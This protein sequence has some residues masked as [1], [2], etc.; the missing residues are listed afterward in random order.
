MQSGSK[1]T[2]YLMPTLSRGLQIFSLAGQILN[3]CL[4]K[5]VVGQFVVRSI[6]LLFLFGIKRN[7]LK[8]GRGR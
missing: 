3:H 1:D 6:N 2:R 7:C 5:R 8:N 4:Q